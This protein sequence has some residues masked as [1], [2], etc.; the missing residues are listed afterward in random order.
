MKMKKA[1]TVSLATL[2]MMSNVVPALAA[3]VSQGAVSEDFP[4]VDYVD[5][6][7]SNLDGQTDEN[8]IPMFIA[9][10]LSK[11]AL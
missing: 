7:L 5:E 8:G 2:A 6:M 10:T 1:L 4:T 3:D 11:L 9:P